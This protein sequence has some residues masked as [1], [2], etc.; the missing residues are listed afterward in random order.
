MTHARKV[1][2][3]EYYLE[4]ELLNN[5]KSKTNQLLTCPVWNLELVYS[6]YGT[7]WCTCC[8]QSWEHLLIPASGSDNVPLMDHTNTEMILMRKGFKLNS[9]KDVAAFFFG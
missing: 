9:E 1:I 6:K 7:I 3:A 8:I 4:T 5:S 2:I